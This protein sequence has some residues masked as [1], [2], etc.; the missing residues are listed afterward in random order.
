VSQ[1]HRSSSVA[2][3]R[4]TLAADHR[5]LAEILRP[6]MSVLDV[7]CGAGTITADIARAVQP[8]GLALGIDREP[9]HIEQAREQ[10]TGQPGLSFECRD[11]L[12]FP[13]EGGFDVVTAARCL[14]WIPDIDR[15]LAR[16]TAAAKPGGTVIVLDF[17]YQH[18]HLEPKP[19]YPV[20]RFFD[21]FRAWREREG[22][23]N[24]LTDHLPEHFA[25]AG[26][27]AIQTSVQDD[28]AHRGDPNFAAALEIWSQVI[29]VCGPSIVAAGLLSQEDC[30]AAYADYDRWCEGE[31]RGMH[32]VLRAVEGM[33]PHGGTTRFAPAENTAAPAVADPGGLGHALGSILSEL[34]AIPSVSPPG[35]TGTIAAYVAGH[36]RRAGYVTEVLARTDGRENVVAQLGQGP[37][38]LAFLAHADTPAV[39]DRAL[40]RCDPFHAVV[41]DDRVVGLGAA[42]GK[43]SLAAQLWLAE[44][45]ARRGGPAKGELVFAMVADAEAMGP[46]GAFFLRE[47]GLLRP[48]R[49]VVGAPTGNRAVLDQPGV[50]WARLTAWGTSADA[51]APDTGDSAILRMVRLI[52]RIEKGLTPKLARRRRTGGRSTL[53][54]GRIEGGSNPRLVPAFCTIDIDRRLL[55][56]EKVDVAFAELLAEVEAAGE[57]GGTVALE[58]VG[59]TNGYTMPATGQLIRALGA[60][61]ASDGTVAVFDGRYFAEDN[62]EVV[63]FGPGTA[64]AAHRP[65]EGVAIAE[66]MNAALVQLALVERLC[67]FGKP[68]AGR[69]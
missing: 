49:L 12:D 67:G 8:H 66:L 13:G 35:D 9:W 7:G 27:V 63:V 42:G 55:P 21:A 24:A 26:L 52:S 30:V 59:G 40:W 15:A 29:V 23:D 37:G 14:Q 33:R 64:D 5:R 45:V 17:N 46:D 22:M 58:F 69:G 53:N 60:P 36:L 50:L 51:G 43:A 28:I 68:P 6:G 39:G 19:P 34:I 54:I 47:A 38:I 57:P 11:I 48:D 31:A 65:N 16:M 25:K 3:N 41:M 44:E 20:R 4:R 56:E 18:L 10:Y 2:M 62:T 1:S 61:T 32:T